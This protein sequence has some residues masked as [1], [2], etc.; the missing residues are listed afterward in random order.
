VVRYHRNR[1]AIR[2]Y[3]RGMGLAKAV[4]LVLGGAL[5]VVVVVTVL[6]SLFRSEDGLID[7]YENR[8]HLIVTP[9]DGCLQT[10][11]LR[12]GHSPRA[13]LDYCAPVRPAGVAAWV[14][15]TKEFYRLDDERRHVVELVA[16]GMLPTGAHAVRY[17]LS[18]GAA[19]D[20]PAQR[21]RDLATPAFWIHLERAAVP[22]DP[23]AAD[24]AAVFVRFQVFDATGAE[25]PVV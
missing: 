7:W 6:P 16:F 17:T 10:F 20:A 5:A 2:A 19:V 24:E 13:K 9:D 3:L 4:E 11:Q 1:T 18:G 8:E 23:G 12:Q 22:V 14:P 15:A 25:I 21:R